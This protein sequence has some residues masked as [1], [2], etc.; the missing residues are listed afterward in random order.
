MDRV[1]SDM[2]DHGR[3][4]LHRAAPGRRSVPADILRRRGITGA[5]D[6]PHEYLQDLL[7]AHAHTRPADRPGRWDILHPVLGSCHDRK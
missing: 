3:R 1:A 5:R 4:R 7:A 2:A 6:V